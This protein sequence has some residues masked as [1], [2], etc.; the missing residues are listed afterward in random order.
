[1]IFVNLVPGA[2]A[3]VAGREGGVFVEDPQF[4]LFPETVFSQPVPSRQVLSD[5]LLNIGFFCM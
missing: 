3:F 5:E 1:L 2:N 4:D